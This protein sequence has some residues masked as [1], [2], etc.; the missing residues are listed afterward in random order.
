MG[1]IVAG[2]IDPVIVLS[3]Q[4][5]PGAT[6]TFINTHP[7]TG[8]LT[9]A[10][11]GP[12]VGGRE[13]AI[14]NASELVIYSLQ[15]NDP[16]GTVIRV[17][18]VLYASQA[19]RFPAEQIFFQDHRMGEVL[20]WLVQTAREQNVELLVAYDDFGAKQ[21]ITIIGTQALSAAQ[22][23]TSTASP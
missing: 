18:E 19:T 13:T 6:T 20:Y 14:D 23:T 17:F 11:S 4:Y 1:R 5:H 16:E 2:Y 7:S 9:W 15:A 10:A 8:V 22:E 21:A 3:E 12:L